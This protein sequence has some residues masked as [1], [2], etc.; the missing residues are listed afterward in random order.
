MDTL[1]RDSSSSSNIAPLAGLFAAVIALILAIVALLQLNS[2]KKTV[3]AHE[4]GVA[5]IASIEE[6][7]GRAVSKSDLDTAIKKLSEGIQSVF[8]N[9]VGPEIG[10]M[11]A[12]IAKLEEAAA[13]KAVAAPAGKPGAAAAPTGVMNADGTYTIASGDNLSRIAAKFGTTVDAIE[14]EN[15]GIDPRRLR[16]GQK[17]RVPKR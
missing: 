10:K 17:I 16:V 7:V 3:A 5:K 12:S 1:S 6:Q 9:Q 13:K 14:A 8:D 15:P 11:K 4:E 2:V